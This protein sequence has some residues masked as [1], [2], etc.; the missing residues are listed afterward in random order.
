VTAKHSGPGG[1]SIESKGVT[2][3]T[4]TPPSQWAPSGPWKISCDGQPLSISGKTIHLQ[5]TAGKWSIGAPSEQRLQKRHGLQ[6]PIDD[7]FQEAFVFVRPTGSAM[8]PA[9][10]AWARAEM[11][12]AIEQWKI[13]FRGEVRVVA[14]TELTPE[15]MK[16]HHLVLWGDPGSNKFLAKLLAAKGESQ[17]QLP[18]QWNDKS[19]KLGAGTYPASSHAAVLVYPNPLASNRYIVLNSSFTFRQGSD[20]TNALQT[21][22]LPDW[23]VVDLS[24]PPNHLAPGNIPDAGFFDEFW[25]LPGK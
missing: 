22:K 18:L 25:R 17:S 6:G 14:D 3:L 11:Q 2:A 4:L 19:L 7:A 20:T 8:H 21:P 10:D 24:T 9:V 23:A 1:L 15:L 16:T 13:V 12:R 5:K